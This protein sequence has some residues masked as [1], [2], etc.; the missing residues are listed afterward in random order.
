MASGVPYPIIAFLNW[1]PR[2][3]A[4]PLA[5]VGQLAAWLKARTREGPG[6]ARRP[7]P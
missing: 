4:T 6:H 1:V 5:G 7:P 2:W 3:L